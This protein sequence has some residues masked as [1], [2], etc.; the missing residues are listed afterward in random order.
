MAKYIVLNLSVFCIGIEPENS[1]FE[2]FTIIASAVYTVRRYSYC[3]VYS[4]V[5]KA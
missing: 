1:R 4:M 5:L 2:L 3:T